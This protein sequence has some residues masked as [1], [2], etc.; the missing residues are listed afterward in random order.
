MHEWRDVDYRHRGIR[1]S[2]AIAIS[3]KIVAGFVRHNAPRA[4]T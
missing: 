1:I 3:C 4:P 2:D